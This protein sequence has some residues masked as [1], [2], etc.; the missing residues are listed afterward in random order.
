RVEAL[1][2]ARQHPQLP[3]GVR[4]GGHGISGRSTNHGG[5]V[6]DL[7]KLNKIEVL[8]EAKRLVRIEPGAR[9][10]DVAAALQPHGWGL[11]SG[12]YGGEGVGGR[13][14][15]GGLGWLSRQHGLSI[16]RLPAV[17][18]VL[19]DGSQVRADAEHS[20][21]VFWAVRGAGG[22]FGIVTAFEFEVY[23]VGNVGWAQLVLDASD[24][25]G[26]L[27]K[28]GAAVEASPRD[29]TSFLILSPARDTQPA[30][31]Y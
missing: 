14:T 10:M 15:A 29:V 28:W 26:F 17:E 16:D 13:A 21:D 5:I 1:A 25:A 12:D 8:D 7:G 9:W 2:C 19:A 24:T 3:R 31:G 4:S 20:A 22:N 11:S 27:V 18:M 6:I 23:E 30:I